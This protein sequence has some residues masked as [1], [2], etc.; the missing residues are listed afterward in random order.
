M[1]VVLLASPQSSQV[2]LWVVRL[3]NGGLRPFSIRAATTGAGALPSS[4]TEQA[5]AA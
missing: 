2:Q 3:H 1:A 4:N 5:L